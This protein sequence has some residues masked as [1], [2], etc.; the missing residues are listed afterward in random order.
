MTKNDVYIWRLIGNNTQYVFKQIHSK[1]TVP[2][3]SAPAER[4]AGL[5]L[6]L[7]ELS[8]GST[9]RHYM[10]TSEKEGF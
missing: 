5:F 6:T 4:K 8:T 9:N 2:S 10:D 3:I 1:Y 7:F